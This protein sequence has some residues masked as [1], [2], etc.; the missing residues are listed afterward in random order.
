MRWS[1]LLQD[2]KFKIEYIKG[3]TNHTDFLSRNIANCNGVHSTKTERLQNKIILE[4]EKQI[5]EV[6]HFYHEL[7]AYD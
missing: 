6:C 5:R 4:S 3:I 7:T 2:Y 1:I